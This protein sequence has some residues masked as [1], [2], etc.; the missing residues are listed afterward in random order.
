[1]SLPLPIGSLLTKLILCISSNEQ[2]EAQY[3]TNV[4]GTINVTRSFLPHFRSRKAGIVIF[5]GSVAGWDATGA[6]GPYGS[7]KFALEGWYNIRFNVPKF[8]GDLIN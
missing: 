8:L 7:S 3:K 5:I 6:V 4:F 2:W 1:M